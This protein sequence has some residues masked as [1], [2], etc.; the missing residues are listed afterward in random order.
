MS[1]GR[2]RVLTTSLWR[3]IAPVAATLVAASLLVV[4]PLPASAKPAEPDR[5][6]PLGA[7]DSAPH[8]PAGSADDRPHQVSADDTSAVDV[9]AATTAWVGKGLEYPITIP[10][11]AIRTSPIQILVSRIGSGARPGRMFVTG[12]THFPKGPAVRT[13]SPQATN[14]ASMIAVT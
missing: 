8:Q 12:G 4:P 14:E 5:P 7:T 6:V 10:T 3:L 2:V 11:T 1:D 13:H 9:A